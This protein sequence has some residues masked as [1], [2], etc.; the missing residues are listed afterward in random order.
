[1]IDLDIGCLD[2]VGEMSRW[3]VVG[4]EMED[5][6]LV[7]WERWSWRVAMSFCSSSVAGGHPNGLGVQLQMQVY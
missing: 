7:V 6:K 5:G 1:V 3:M 2:K 4:G